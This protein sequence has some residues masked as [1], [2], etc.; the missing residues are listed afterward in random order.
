V[1]TGLIENGIQALQNVGY[2]VGIL[3]HIL[4]G[5]REVL[6]IPEETYP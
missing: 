2:Q 1:V 3:V 6:Y 4:V 5:L